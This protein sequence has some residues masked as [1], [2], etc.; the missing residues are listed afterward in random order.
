MIKSTDKLIVYQESEC[1]L[2]P[3]A[4]VVSKD[5]WEAGGYVDRLDV[6]ETDYREIEARQLG[7]EARYCEEVIASPAHDSSA[8]YRWDMAHKM[9][10]S[11]DQLLGLQQPTK[12]AR[13][14][15]LKKLN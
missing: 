9:L 15:E 4:G 1:T 6:D 13:W 3:E 2:T 12:K 5:D 14:D 7:S 8:Q 10:D 11:I